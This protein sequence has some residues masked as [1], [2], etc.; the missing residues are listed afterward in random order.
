MNHGWWSD[1][2]LGAKVDDDFDSAPV[3]FSDKVVEVRKCPEHRIDIAVIG[4][5]VAKVRHGRR[6]ERRQPDGVDAE[7]HKIVEP[8]DHARE[9]ADAVII[10]ILERAR[11]NPDGPPQLP[12]RRKFPR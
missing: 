12:P 11:I 2:W 7:P 1:V 8:R 5:V 3:R 4:D 9:V 10:R 6:V